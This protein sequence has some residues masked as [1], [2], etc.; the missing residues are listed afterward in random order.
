MT[1]VITFG[2]IVHVV[3]IAL[4]IIVPLGILLWIIAAFGRGMSR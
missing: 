3:E 2:D 4:A 1:H